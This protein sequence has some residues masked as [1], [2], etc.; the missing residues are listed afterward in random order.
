MELH[1]NDPDRLFGDKGYDSESNTIGKPTSG[2][3]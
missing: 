1:D 2:E 3:I